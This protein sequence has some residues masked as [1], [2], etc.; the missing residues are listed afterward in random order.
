MKAYC[1]LNALINFVATLV[2][3]AKIFQLAKN[4]QITTMLRR[5]IINNYYPFSFLSVFSLA[6]SLQLILTIT[7]LTD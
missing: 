5:V 1:Q 3:I 4:S 2:L 7:H 6:K